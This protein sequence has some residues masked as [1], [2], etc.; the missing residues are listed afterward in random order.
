MSSVYGVRVNFI[1]V[2]DG[3]KLNDLCDLWSL[4]L[5]INTRDDETG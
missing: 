2:V 5:V 1:S 4:Y 3:S